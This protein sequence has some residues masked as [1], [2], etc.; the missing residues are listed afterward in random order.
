MP[1]LSMVYE[2]RLGP[3]AEH[4]I[5]TFGIRQSLILLLAGGEQDIRFSCS[6]VARMLL[7]DIYDDVRFPCSYMPLY[8]SPS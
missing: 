8:E 3:K 1:S 7:V 5:P 2:L 4:R 6:S